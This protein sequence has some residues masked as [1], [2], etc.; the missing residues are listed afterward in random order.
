MAKRG[1]TETRNARSRP[2]AS[3]P[4]LHGARQVGRHNRRLQQYQWCIVTGTY[5]RTIGSVHSKIQTRQ[6]IFYFHFNT[7]KR[8]KG[9]VPVSR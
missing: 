9:M 7:E 8:S 5:Q 3:T 6:D 2:E 4:I 1:E